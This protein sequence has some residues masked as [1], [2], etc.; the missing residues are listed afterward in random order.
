MAT[1]RPK[2]NR[3]EP[4]GEQRVL[5]MQLKIGDRLVDETGEYEVIGRPY[6]NERWQ[7]RSR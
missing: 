5:P 7:G 6:T 2:K 4:P 3:P 1:P